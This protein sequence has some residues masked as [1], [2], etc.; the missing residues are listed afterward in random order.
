[1]TD[2]GAPGSWNTLG[3]NPMIVRCEGCGK[4]IGGRRDV[5][6]GGR[7]GDDHIDYGELEPDENYGGEYDGE[8][9]CGGCYDGLEEEEG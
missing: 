8:D 7:H 9:Y 4:I 3:G 1:M 5:V 2:E 6:Y